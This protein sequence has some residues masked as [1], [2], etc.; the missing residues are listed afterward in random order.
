MCIYS[1][2]PSWLHMPFEAVPDCFFFSPCREGHSRTAR[3][4]TSSFSHPSQADSLWKFLF[5]S[6]HFLPPPVPPP[7]NQNVMRSIVE[8]NEDNFCLNLK[9]K[10]G[11]WDEGWDFVNKRKTSKPRRLCNAL[12]FQLPLDLSAVWTRPERQRQRESV[13]AGTNA[14]RQ[15]S[16]LSCQHKVAWKAKRTEKWVCCKD[17]LELEERWFGSYNSK[18]KLMAHSGIH[19][20][21]WTRVVNICLFNF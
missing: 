13:H 1:M 17:P 14:T 4:G 15:A 5:L 12:L 19:G 11:G 3:S 18:V 7:L 2:N 21:V 20:P 9:L 16:H 8:D 6:F 10:G